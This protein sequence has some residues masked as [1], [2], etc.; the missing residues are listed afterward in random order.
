MFDRGDLKYVILEL[1]RDRPMHGYE[2]MRDLEDRSSGCYS[3]SPGSVYPTL[4]LLEDEG[5]VRSEQENGRKIYSITDEGRAFLD[6]NRDR[7]EDILERVAGF[8]RHFSDSAMSDLTRSFV[9][10]AQ[11]SFEQAVRRPGDADSL[12]RL[13]EILERAVR[14]VEAVGAE[15]KKAR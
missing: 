10:L 14:E 9:K 4:Q 15:K 2:V 1:L 7:V 13:R 8:A 12:S 5:Y 3:A 6:Q 11:A